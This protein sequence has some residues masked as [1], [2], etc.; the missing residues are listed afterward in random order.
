MGEK[1]KEITEPQK[2]IIL[3]SPGSK[4]YKLT[5]TDAGMLKVEVQE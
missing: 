4:K 1:L 5:I 2:E 3:I